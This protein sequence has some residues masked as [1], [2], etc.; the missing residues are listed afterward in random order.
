[1]K[2]IIEIE[3]KPDFYK[4]Q[5]FAEVIKAKIMD[6]IHDNYWLKDMKLPKIKISS[7]LS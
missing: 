7:I 1:M 2:I 5:E 4:P 3:A 6:I